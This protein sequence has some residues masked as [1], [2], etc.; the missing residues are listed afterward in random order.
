MVIRIFAALGGGEELK[1][2]K[3]KEENEKCGKKRLGELSQTVPGFEN[4]D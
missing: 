4:S 2:Q 3:K 1:M